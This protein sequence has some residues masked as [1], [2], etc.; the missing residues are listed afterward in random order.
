MIKLP[1]AP[2]E[3]IPIGAGVTLPALKTAIEQVVG[4]NGLPMVVELTE[5]KPAGFL[6]NPIEAVIIS[7][8]TDAKNYYKM[9]LT[10]YGSGG[11][12]R[13]MVYYVGKSKYTRNMS[14]G[15]YVQHPSISTDIIAGVTRMLNSN[16]AQQQ[17]MYYEDLAEVVVTAVDMVRSGQVRAAAP[18]PT[19]Q[20]APRPA[21][22]PAQQSR[23]A[24]AAARQSAPATRQ[25]PRPSSQARPTSSSTASASQCSSRQPASIPRSASQA[26]SAQRPQRAQSNS[27]QRSDSS[28]ANQ[29]TTQTHS[30]PTQPGSASQPA[31]VPLDRVEAPKTATTCTCPH[32]GATVRITVPVT[33][34][35]LNVTC[36]KC[37]LKFPLEVR[38]KRS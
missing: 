19:P 29:N 28:S 2:D 23:P 20:P 35:R 6:T 25:A 13:L 18:A 24:P 5:V 30:A 21:P 9:V 14:I 16:K 37:H 17:E 10:R 11:S 1:D 4:S 27:A 22:Q 34:C 31:F 26:R 15:Q 12:T 36:G 3:R 33:D 38:R 7:H 8:A 32:C